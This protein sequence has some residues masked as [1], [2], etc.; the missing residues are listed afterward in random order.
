[1]KFFFGS[2]ELE[3]VSEWL[4]VYFNL[5]LVIGYKYTILYNLNNFKWQM[6]TG[7]LYCAF[8]PDN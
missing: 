1:M 4:R 8:A 3:S 5:I 2:S 7:E 6:E